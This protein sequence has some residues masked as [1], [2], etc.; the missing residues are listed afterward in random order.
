MT[1]RSPPTLDPAAEAYIPPET[2]LSPH[3]EAA[4]DLLLFMRNAGIRADAVEVG[5]SGVRLLNVVDDYPRKQPAGERAR[6][7]ADPEFDD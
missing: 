7:G 3:C 5:D 4:K 1:R 2:P 6:R